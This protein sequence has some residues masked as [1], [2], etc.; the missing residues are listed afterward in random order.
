MPMNCDDAI[1]F[2][3]WLLNGTLEAGERDEVRRHLA[4]CES[5]RAA[6]NDTRKAWTIFGQHLPSDAL[7][8]LAYGEVPAG[9]DPDVAARHLA[10]CPECAAE[11]ELA[12]TSRHL[13]EDDKIAVFP[14]VRARQEKSVGRDRSWRAAALAAGIATLVALGGWNHEF[15]VADHL[16]DRLARASRVEPARTAA[17]AVVA[18]SSP[19]EEQLRSQLQASRER[20]DELAKSLDDDAG[21]LASIEEK[22]S[23]LLKPQVNP[24]SDSVAGSSDVVRDGKRAEAQ[25]LPGS[26]TTVPILGADSA[27]AVRDVEILD[28]HGGVLWSG[29]GLRSTEGQEYRLAIPPGFLKPGTYTIQLYAN[30][31]GKRVKRESYPIRVE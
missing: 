11:L 28:S 21:K 18:S 23:T 31:N 29:S 27:D 14:G 2:L 1:E 22:A 3:P 26:R 9:V 13:E 16:S 5:C 19:A 8:A 25:V 24:W 10:G 12:R 7:V 20:Q 4:T 6:L 17:P 15:R 30:E